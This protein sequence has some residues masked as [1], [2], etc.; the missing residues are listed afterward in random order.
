MNYETLYLNP[1]TKTMNTL[2]SILTLAAIGIL[3]Y[4]LYPKQYTTTITYAM[5]AAPP[6]GWYDYE[7]KDL[8]VHTFDA[9]IGHYGVGDTITYRTMLGDYFAE[10]LKGKYNNPYFAD[11]TVSDTSRV[12]I[13]LDID[14]VAFVR[15]VTEDTIMDFTV[16]HQIVTGKQ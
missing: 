15:I 4:L 3:I 9:H 1:K 5:E 6:H 11:L 10:Q 2:K 8:Q 14:K 13:E 7:G 12:R 16:T